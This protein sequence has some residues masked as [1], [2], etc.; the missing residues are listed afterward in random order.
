MGG[1]CTHLPVGSLWGNCVL[2]MAAQ[3]LKVMSIS[4]KEL[5][6]LSVVYHYEAS[7]SMT[8]RAE[9]LCKDRGLI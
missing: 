8:T 3:T 7:P 9:T 6:L 2:P 4:Y 1:H 5:V